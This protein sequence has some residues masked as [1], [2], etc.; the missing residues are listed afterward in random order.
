MRVTVKNDKTPKVIASLKAM[1]G[2]QVL[3]GIP[4]LTNGRQGS[5]I[6]NAALAYMNDRGVPSMNIPA[7]P[8]LVVGV[9]S[10]LPK[11][12]KALQVYAAKA[13]NNPLE[14]EKGMA[15]AGM[16]CRDAVKR[17]IVSQEG[18]K[19]PAKRTIELRKARG[20]AGTKALIVTGS[21]LNSITY[22]VERK[23]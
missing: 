1:K 5:G 3:V 9:E 7:R 14:I 6:G 4:D 12:T 11:A 17:R 21:L 18:M 8:F 15:A 20:F 2:A 10:A 13:F 23:K 22:V 19:A 16:I